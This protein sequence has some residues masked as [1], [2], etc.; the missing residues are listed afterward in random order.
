MKILLKL[1]FA[2]LILGLT[3]TSFSFE[4]TLVLPAGVRNF[5]LRTLYTEADNKTDED[6]NIKSLADRLWKPLRF[7]N[8]ISSEPLMKQKQLQA[9]LIQQGWSE[10][11]SIGDF[12]AELDAQINV[13]APIF[14]FGITDRITLAAAVPFYSA[15]TDIQVGF[16]TNSGADRFI[17]AL[18]DP[19]MSNTNAAVES[20]TKLADAIQ[21]LNNKL[22]DNKYSTFDRWNDSGI[23]DISLLAKALLANG[24]VFK[25]ALTGGVTVPTGQVE[26]PD[27]F[28]D[29]PFGDGQ[30]DLFSQFT[31]DQQL[32]SSFLINQYVRYTYQ[33]PGRRSFR[34]QT[35]AESIEVEKADLDFKLGD[36][37][38]AGLSL[39]YEQPM[40]GIQ[41]LAGALRYQ[42]YGDRFEAGEFAVE[43]EL[44]RETDQLANYWQLGLGYS[45]LAAFRRKE[46]ALPLLAMVQ[47]RKQVS[48][49]NMPRTHF[50]QV[51]LNIFF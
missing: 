37:I 30:Y 34:L 1:L 5:N 43:S 7:R 49:R 2:G 13:W 9:L 10:D 48:S 22:V 51:D 47:Y 23:G 4:N 3:S 46:F 33:A 26:S 8:V 17:G 31:F 15:S 39:Q 32:S 36:Q 40:T 35:A 16:R 45:T 14:A 27:V 38:E 42:K 44:Q 19:D 12:Y 18:T 41:V 24:D 50:T 28:T 11:D 25:F 29:L 21:R 20:A 6:G